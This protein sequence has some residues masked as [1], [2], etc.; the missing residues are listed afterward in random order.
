[1]VFRP[2]L[3]SDFYGWSSGF[4]SC[5]PPRAILE[6]FYTTWL[7]FFTLQSLCGVHSVWFRC[8]F[9]FF[10][11]PIDCKLCTLHT[12]PFSKTTFFLPA[13]W[14]LI[15]IHFGEMWKL[16]CRHLKSFQDHWSSWIVSTETH[17][18]H[19]RLIKNLDGFSDFGVCWHC[20]QTALSKSKNQSQETSC[21]DTCSYWESS[22]SFSKS[23]WKCSVSV[24]TKSLVA[25]TFSHKHRV[26]EMGEKKII[27]EELLKMA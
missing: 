8:L 17:F 23:S 21:D 2:D 1:M 11:S 14:L 5:S 18:W 25:A 15:V 9:F 27:L 6:L 16:V 20:W 13:G 3:K 26:I 7:Y 19:I 4:Q 24:S 10:S 12:W 22:L